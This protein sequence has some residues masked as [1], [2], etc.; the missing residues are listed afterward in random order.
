MDRASAYED[1]RK[2]RLLLAEPHCCVAEGLAALLATFIDHI[3]IVHTGRDLVTGVADDI[4]IVV[5]EISMPDLP[6]LPPFQSLREQHSQTKFIVLSSHEEPLIVRE[7]MHA[8][9]WGYVLKKSPSTELLQAIHEVSNGSHYLSPGLMATLINTPV[10]E[11]KL[12]KRQRE[13]L[14]RMALGLST[15]EIAIELGISVRTVESHRQSLLD[16]LNMHNSVSLVRE[17]SRLGLIREYAIAAMD[18]S[19]R[20]PP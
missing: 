13:I 15:N 18:A 17:A 8:G 7:A 9:V 2:I 14:E 1:I 10:S 12:T 16:T 19:R 20:R 6:G 4:D 11:R 5:S 3:A